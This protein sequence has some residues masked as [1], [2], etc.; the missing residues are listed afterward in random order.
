MFGL[1]LPSADSAGVDSVD[2]DLVDV[3][4]A[5]I[6]VL[7]ALYDTVVIHSRRERITRTFTHRMSLW[8][9]DLDALPDMPRWLRPFARFDSCDHVGVPELSIRANIDEWLA[10]QGVDL[11]G[12]PVVMLAQA[13]SMGYVFN[14]I[15]LYWCAQPDG[16]P[17]CVVAEVH[18]TYGERHCYLLRPDANDIADATK[19][20]YV[21]PFLDVDG[22]YEM[23]V[24]RPG[25]ELSVDVSLRRGG[26]TLFSVSLRGDRHPATVRRVARTLLRHPL[27]SFRISA[28]IRLHGIWL[29]AR[30]LPVTPRAPHLVK[31]GDT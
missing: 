16:R 21:S 12:G 2:V 1:V 23:R 6:D 14:P 8:L 29:W 17:E 27:G 10:T 5:S 26:E 25:I 3:D 11:H 9:V 30:R 31:R 20:F 22:A 18:N 7:P 24:S 4:S 19:E 15:T 13:R 28:L